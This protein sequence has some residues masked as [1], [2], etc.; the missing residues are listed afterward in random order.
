[1][2]TVTGTRI[3]QQ[4]LLGVITLVVIALASP[5]EAGDFNDLTFAPQTGFV[6]LNFD[7]ERETVA[8]AGRDDDGQPR[9]ALITSIGTDLSV[10]ELA[11]PSDA[12][13]I[14]SGANGNERNALFVL[15]ATRVLKLDA[16]DAELVEV[17]E[18]ASLY[19]G[20]SYAPLTSA[21]DFAVDIDDD[22]VAELVV[23]DFDVLT[24]LDGDDFAD[25]QVLA[26]PTL[27]RSFE[28]AQNFRPART[29]FIP[30]AVVSVRGDE[31]LQYG[32]ASDRLDDE[33][34]TASISKL[35]LGLSS[36][37]D[38]ERFYNGDPELDQ[39]NVLLRE[40]E[41]LV[42]F[43][44]DGLPDLVT[45]ETVSS[46]VFD[47]DTTY[48]LYIAKSPYGF[49]TEPD[50]TF[51][52]Q[53]Y[54]FGLSSVA[55]DEQRTALVAPGVRI[56]LRTIIGALFSRSV[57]IDIAIYASD[58]NGQF[59]E[60]PTADV[61]AKLKFDFGSGQVESPTVTFG[62]LDGDGQQ[63]LILKRGRDK[64]G[65]RRNLG[66]GNFA[67]RDANL[68]ITAPKD[69]S[70]VIAADLDGDGQDEIL[71][72]YGLQDGV[73][74]KRRVRLLDPGVNDSR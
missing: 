59:A 53:G 12:V 68:D 3:N 42:D 74:I 16:V 36:E 32:I 48:R 4:T 55:L 61:S 30:G 63:D 19:R 57:N 47:K 8:L 39:S 56:G 43:T 46:G 60:M 66:E 35:G 7:A 62:D 24:T 10:T 72:R 11:M 2:T 38:I 65:W 23:Q 18:V 5:T 25:R 1:M 26:F 22:Q 28:R 67:G 37:R 33:T 20:L 14:D 13:A 71:V 15:C 41:L 21:L 6:I 70:G 64:L 34:V 58:S 51:S 49:S 17:A 44:G 31:L 9:L 50:T 54:Q 27:R 40:P 29:A 45:L 52:G 73:D 69:G